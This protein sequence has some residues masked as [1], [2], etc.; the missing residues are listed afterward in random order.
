M[1]ARTSAK[2]GAELRVGENERAQS[3]GRGRSMILS[4]VEACKSFL[5]RR[6]SRQSVVG[7]RGT[8]SSFVAAISPLC[9]AALAIRTRPDRLQ[10]RSTCSVARHAA[11]ACTLA[12][13]CVPIDVHSDQLLWPLRLS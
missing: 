12:P 4:A 6:L 11:L 10:H 7:R 5:G 3:A 13:M 8:S 9:C 1:S 2:R